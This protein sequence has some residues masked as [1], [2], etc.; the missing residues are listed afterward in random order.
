MDAHF[1]ELNQ[2]PAHDRSLQ[3]SFLTFSDSPA[4][5]RRSCG[6]KDRQGSAGLAA[7][8]QRSVPPAHPD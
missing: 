8:V 2:K 1:D 7:S 5:M 3:N 4:K 6:E